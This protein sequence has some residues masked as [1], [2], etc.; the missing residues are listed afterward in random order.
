ME[1]IMLR[2]LALTFLT[3][4]GVAGVGAQE[5]PRTD[6][7]VVIPI[8]EYRALRLRA[9]PPEPPPES[10]PI[11]M[12]VARADYNLRLNG[13]WIEG[14]ARLAVDVFADGLVV[15]PLPSGFVVRGARGGRLM[16]IAGDGGQQ[17]ILSKRGRTVVAL[18]VVA[19]VTVAGGS[20][21]ITVRPAHLLGAR[22]EE[23]HP[24]VS[25]V[26][27]V[28]PGR[29]IDLSVKGGVLAER[30]ADVE[31]PWV[32]YATTG[33]ALT[34]T[35]TKRVEETRS[36][37][38]P[39]I[40]A[41]VIETVGLAEETGLLTANV[42]IEVTQGLLP[43]ATLA[44]PDAL[45]VNQVSGPL[46]ADWEFRPGSL[47]VVFLEPV[48]TQTTLSVSAEMPVSREGNIAVP[49][50]R[51]TGAER[52]TGG[53]A[54]EVLGAGEI[55]DRQPRGLDPADP[56]DFGDGLA[57]R[58][59]PSMIAFRYR[60][61]DGGA[62]RSLAVNVLRYT[63]QAVLIANVE[64]A[65]YDVLVGE[66]GKILVR[67]RYAVRNNQRAF[68]AMKLPEGATLWSAAVASRPLRPGA[69]P[70]GGLLVPLVKG[71]SGE[72]TPSF[73]VEVTYVHRVDAWKED[74]RA[75]LVLPALDL[76]VSRTGL[77]LHYSPR[78]RV[79]PQP[80]AFRPE[81]DSGP[82]SD[83]LRREEILAAVE[84]R[85]ATDTE[86]G[87]PAGIVGGVVG[88]LPDAPVPP[89]AAAAPSTAGTDK[90]IG[91]FRRQSAG[92]SVTG[93][94]P[95]RAAFPEFG[96]RLFLMSE[97]TAE[98]RPPSLEISYKREGRW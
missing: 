73:V 54:V 41:S 1:A 87:I 24:A 95:V 88:G 59:T 70:D 78:F 55:A 46:V 63:P 42:R 38:P 10:P 98:G 37:Q 89:R 92:R 84:G 2:A 76:P 96:A 67:A 5:P 25:R 52:E 61:Q 39:R 16:T 44:L 40:R 12:A 17:V 23:V 22:P 50:V 69:A 30:P 77:V 31:K 58:A 15:V 66:E 21:S 28:L 9:Y 19:P 91:D 18:D 36:A 7:W 60:P 14:E 81:T 94:V 32:A 53:V 6:G 62:A 47:R 43:A 20:E 26:A 86:P 90:L 35:W 8:D 64:E 65:R 4:V 79:K 34:M 93:V 85:D 27:L 13:D 49:L 56:S 3:A 68:L 72:D 97:L 74:G 45:I 57:S 48:S 29:D 71:R 83:A 80:G 75:T 33:Q 82:F 51:V 11:G